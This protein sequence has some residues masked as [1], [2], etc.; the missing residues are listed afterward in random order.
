VKQT[1]KTAFKDGH[2]KVGGRKKGSKNKDTVMKEQIVQSL[3]DALVISQTNLKTAV[4]TVLEENPLGLLR[5]MQGFD[6]KNL[7]INMGGNV[8]LN[9]TGNIKPDIKKKDGNGGNGG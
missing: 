6:D 4:T 7:N 9:Y 1:P 3:V 5:L 2:K 8:N